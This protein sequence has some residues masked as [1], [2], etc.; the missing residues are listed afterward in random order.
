MKWQLPSLASLRTF[1]AA[2]RHL[3]FT[4]AA[5]E[6]N[7]TPSAVSRQVRHMEDYLG[8]ELFLRDKK[9]LILTD[10]GR[11]YVRDI[12]SG[13]ELMQSATVN[14]LANQ[15]RKG[16]INLATPPAFGVK[17][18]IPRLDKFAS[19]HPDIHVNLSTRAKPFDFEQE[20]IDAAIYYGSNDWPGTLTERLLGEEL[21]TACSPA[22]LARFPGRKAKV[23]DLPR[24]ILLQ[25]TSRHNNW[26]EWLEK[27]NASHV[28]PWAGPRFEHVYMVVQAAVAGLGIALIP[29]LLALDEL[30]SG[31][32][33]IPF[34]GATL[35]TQD[36][37]CLVYP[38][39]K[40]SDPKLTIFR[41]WLQEQA[42][43]S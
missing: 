18:L 42:A 34:P 17:W 43:H 4:H 25:Q 20:R 21:I 22:Y 1:E 35:I 13:M 33:V 41:R 9:R 16:M 40:K 24:H 23:A 12:R 3:S 26:Q 6:L 7:L 28:N 29:R 8:V 27:N 37:Y 5:A 11:L 30:A 39:A 31:R 38:A 10:A 2:A 36:A 14:L 19:K 15:G 32:L